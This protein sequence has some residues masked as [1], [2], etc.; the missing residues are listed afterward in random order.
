M[1][2]PHVDYDTDLWM[3]VPTDWTGLPWKGPKAWGRAMADAWWGDTDLEPTRKDVKA[4]AETLRAGAER[5]PA[6][7]PG[8]DVY[9]FLP[10]PRAMPLPVFVASVEAEGDREETLRALVTTEDPDL[11]EKPLVEDFRTELLGAG[12]RSLRYTQ[13][14]GREIIAGVRYAWR[15]EAAGCD[16]VVVVST[17]DTRYLLGAM[18]EL[19]AF[20]AR[21]SVPSTT[22]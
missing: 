6:T 15:A 5:Y 8:F 21:V 12:L 13:S 16:V 10:D 2:R 18:D 9:L 19:D 22:T 11:V 3:M 1:S 14:A 17:T 4:L 20:A 7:H